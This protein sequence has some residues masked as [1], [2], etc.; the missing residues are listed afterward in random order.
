V[1]RGSEW[2]SRI[3]KLHQGGVQSQAREE[4]EVRKEKREREESIRYES[5]CKSWMH[6][7]IQIMLIITSYDRV[8]VILLHHDLHL[9]VVP[10]PRSS[11][12]VGLPR[13]FK[14]SVSILP[15]RVHSYTDI[16]IYIYILYDVTCILYLVLHLLSS[17][18]LLLL[19]FSPFLTSPSTMQI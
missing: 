14:S 7:I 3:V 17:P 1:R 6:N 11:V 10:P 18:L 19:P 2:S 13:T 9:L 15:H 5:V 12:R 16:C 8:V 4:C